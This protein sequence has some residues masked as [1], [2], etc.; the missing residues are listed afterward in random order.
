MLIVDKQRHGTGWEGSQNLNYHQ[1][2]QQYVEFGSQA[3]SLRTYPHNYAPARVSNP[4]A[5]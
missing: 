5:A 4:E 2:S 3:M 1:R